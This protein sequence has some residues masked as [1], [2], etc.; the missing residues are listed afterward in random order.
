MF[1]KHS[2][3]TSGLARKMPKLRAHENFGF[4]SIIQLY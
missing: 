2:I 1:N 3:I 4:Y